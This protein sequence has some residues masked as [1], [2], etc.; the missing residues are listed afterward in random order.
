MAEPAPETEEAVPTADSLMT[1]LTL[2][3]VV[4]LAAAAADEIEELDPLR[5]VT[6]GQA[7]EAEEPFTF[8]SLF[9]L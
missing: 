6:P 7:T 1:S 5:F 4:T 9:S 8:G 2:V 3:T